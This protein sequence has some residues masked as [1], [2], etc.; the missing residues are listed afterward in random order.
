MSRISVSSFF[1]LPEVSSLHPAPLHTGIDFL[2]EEQFRNWL[3]CWVIIWALFKYCLWL[4][5]SL[6]FSPGPVNQAVP[7]A[8]QVII[9]PFLGLPTSQ[10]DTRQSPQPQW[11]VILWDVHWRTAGQ[12]GC[13][14]CGAEGLKCVLFRYLLL[15]AMLSGLHIRKT[16]GFA[17]WMIWCLISQFS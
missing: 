12:D 2:W 16:S 14:Y 5:F 8:A 1:H 17:L 13:C 6:S 10:N 11:H 15:H 9:C 4:R 7:I 3:R